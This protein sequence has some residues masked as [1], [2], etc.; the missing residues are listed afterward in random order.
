MVA[1]AGFRGVRGAAVAGSDLGASAL[2]LE[3]GESDSRDDRDT[4]VDP[5][6]A[7]ARSLNSM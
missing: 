3:R 5:G 4:A 6:F 7:V 2:G 1:P